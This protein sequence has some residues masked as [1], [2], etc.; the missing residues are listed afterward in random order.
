[1]FSSRSAC[2]FG[3]ISRLYKRMAGFITQGTQFEKQ[4]GELN[5]LPSV[6][7]SSSNL[8]M[9]CLDYAAFLRQEQYYLT[10]VSFTGV[11]NGH[12]IFLNRTIERHSGLQK[13]VSE[14]LRRLTAGITVC[15][16]RNECCIPFKAV[17][18]QWNGGH[19]QYCMQYTCRHTREPSCRA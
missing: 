14:N 11:L 4:S 3:R 7:T 13:M 19:I 5:C 8:W 18:Q 1:M 6:E 10:S 12:E 15:N 2:D 17:P 9:K 16:T